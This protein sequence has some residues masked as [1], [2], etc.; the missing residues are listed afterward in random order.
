[1]CYLSLGTRESWGV[2]S[3]QA[4]AMRFESLLFRSIDRSDL[5]SCLPYFLGGRPSLLYRGLR[6][7]SRRLAA[8][9][10]SLLLL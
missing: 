1:M 4:E 5:M 7:P 8:V 2:T 3:F 6:D 10:L 9:V